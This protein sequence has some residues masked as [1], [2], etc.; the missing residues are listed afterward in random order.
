M[1]APPAPEATPSYRPL[2]FVLLGVAGV[3]GALWLTWTDPPPPQGKQVGQLAP[4]VA[5][6]DAEGRPVQLSDYGGKVVLISFWGTWC[7]PCRQQL[8]HEVELMTGKYKGRPFAILGVA[9]DSAATLRRFL[10][11]H[12]L[13]WPNIADE[14]RSI[15][16][17]WNVEAVP[18]AV[19]VD[20]DGVVRHAWVEGVSP[21]TL[22]PAVDRMLAEVEKN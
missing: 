10:N 18:S 22:W 1:S 11:D 17:Q 20:P 14:D 7:G 2:L 9:Q 8:P 13:P 19:L 12:P 3:G 15:A 16:A 21:R 4:E 5:G 6:R